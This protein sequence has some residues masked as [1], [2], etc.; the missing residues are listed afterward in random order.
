MGHSNSWSV[1][2]S[3]TLNALVAA[4]NRLKVADCSGFVPIGSVRSA[5]KGPPVVDRSTGLADT[6]ASGLGEMRNPPLTRLTAR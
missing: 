5:D 1:N 6:Q 2:G 3:L 4:P